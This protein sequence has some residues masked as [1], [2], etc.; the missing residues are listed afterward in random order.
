MNT[1]NSRISSA[2]L[3]QFKD[4]SDWFWTYGLKPSEVSLEWG[5]ESDK[6]FVPLVN[7]KNIL[8]VEYEKG[9]SKKAKNK[10]KEQQQKEQCVFC[11]KCSN[12][13]DD[14]AEYSSVGCGNSPMCAVG[15]K[16]ITDVLKQVKGTGIRM[17]YLMGYNEPYA[18]HEEDSAYAGKGDK[19]V[20]PREA[21]LWWRL[22]VQPAAKAAGL[23]LVS[24]T[25]G[26]SAKKNR[27]MV[28]FLKACYAMK[29]HKY[30]CTPKDI[31]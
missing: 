3:D 5:K 21:A 13:N 8:S 11:A 27:W 17:N 15:G 20:D 18:T 22:W 19:S 31:E 2:I 7:L 12:D 9:K 25:T 1:G 26:I 14:C 16:N 29:G 23:K 4:S 28:N 30:P 10:R 24:P 6:E